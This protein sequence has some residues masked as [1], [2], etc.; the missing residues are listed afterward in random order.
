MTV[1]YHQ[2][3]L[4]GAFPDCPDIFHGRYPFLFLA[5]W[6][7]KELSP[8]PLQTGFCV[9]YTELR[10]QRMV[11]FTKPVCQAIYSSLSSMLIF[12]TSGIELYVTENSPKALNSLIHRLKDNHELTLIKIAYDLIPPQTASF[13]NVKQQYVNDHFYYAISS[14][15]RFPE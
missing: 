9:S 12:D 15:Y 5:L 2:I 11:D 4:K 14:P 8:Y 6:K 1:K 3:S 13:P 7:E 10:F